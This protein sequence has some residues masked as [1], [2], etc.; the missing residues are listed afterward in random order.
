MK[1]LLQYLDNEEKDKF[2]KFIR[3]PYFNTRHQLVQVFNILAVKN[4]KILDNK[5][6]FQSLYPGEKYNDTRIRKVVSDFSSIFEKFISYRGIQQWDPFVLNTNLLE[7]LQHKAMDEEFSSAYRSITKQMRSKFQKDDSYYRSFSRIE[8]LN[9]YG[10]YNKYVKTSVENLRNASL[11]MD[12]G[13]IYSK[14]HLA[15]DIITHKEFNRED[16]GHEISFFKEIFEYI[17]TRKSLITTEH[18]DLYIIYL[19]VKTSIVE[20]NDDI[21][22]ELADYVKNNEKRIDKYRLGYYYLYLTSMHWLKINSGRVDYFQP[23]I[24]IYKHLESRSLIRLEAYIQ[25]DVFNSIVM[26]AINTK[27]LNWLEKFLKKNKDHIEPDF[28]SD[29]YSLNS[30]KLQF[31]KA[32]Y[33]KVLQNLNSVEFRDPNYFINAKTLLMK[34][35]YELGDKEGISFTLDSLKHYALRNKKLV[36]QQVNNIKMLVKFFRLLLK[37]KPEDTFNAN[38]FLELLGKE[39]SFVPQRSWLGEKASVILNNAGFNLRD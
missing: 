12:L 11:Y 3:S 34:T 31:E 23:L 10:A 14:L 36:A 6:L 17:E 8:L 9:Y 27:E 33:N 18:P 21:I 38:K 7:S 26:A 25:H 35:L 5:E 28:R 1:N 37:L 4:D 2:G 32:E 16:F 24:K 39:R 15:R 20:N 29:V 13:F 30:A 22:T 19:T